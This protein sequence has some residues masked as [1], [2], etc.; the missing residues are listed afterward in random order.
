[1]LGHVHEFD[2]AGVRSK[3][4]DDLLHTKAYHTVNRIPRW[5]A[6]VGAAA[7]CACLG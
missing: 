7:F 2:L 1:V 5:A 4:G 6:S 3:D